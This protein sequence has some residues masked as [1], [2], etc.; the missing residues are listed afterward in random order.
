MAYLTF[1]IEKKGDTR[2]GIFL[3][4]C[5]KGKGHMTTIPPG[6]TQA[7]GKSVVLSH[8]VETNGNKHNL[9]TIRL[10]DLRRIVR[11]SGYKLLDSK[12]EAFGITRIHKS[13]DYKDDGKAG[14]NKGNVA[15]ILFAGAIFLRFVSKSE[16]VTEQKLKQFI[17]ALPNRNVGRISQLSPNKISSVRKD[18]VHFFWGL[19]QNNY[20]AVKNMDLWSAWKQL[21][22][23]S[24]TYANSARVSEYADAFYTNNLHNRIVVMADGESDQ[25]GTK[26]DVRVTANDHNKKQ[27]PVDLA[28]S[29]KA[30]P[31]K[32]FGQYGGV[33]YDVQK[34]MWDEFFGIK[35]SFQEAQFY[36]KFGTED[37]DND[38]RDA[39]NYSYEKQAPHAAKALQTAKGLDKFFKAVNFHMTRDENPVYLVQLTDRG[40]AIQYDTN[41]LAEKL[42][43]FKFKS[44]MGKSGQL[45]KLSIMTEIDGKEDV[46][47]DMRVKKGDYLKDGTPYYRNIFEKGKHFTKLLSVLID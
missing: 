22:S 25:T 2:V 19:S 47:L 23:A 9:R 8:I 26:V 38:A 14:F 33:S 1:D 20:D 46:F 43:G 32:Q 45:P 10:D 27:V 40:E 39:L 6:N 4:K 7:S 18:A 31:V 34:K 36:S 35:M 41:N 24:L 37:H 15:E 42:K 28:I 17:R 21:I 11:G 5:K 29:L 12:G 16:K 3:D 13:D 30:G 44:K